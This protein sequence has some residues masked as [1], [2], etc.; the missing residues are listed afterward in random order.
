MQ[1]K[2][3]DR[4]KFNERGYERGRGFRGRPGYVTFHRGYVPG[5][6]IYAEK[7]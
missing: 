3:N 4:Q 5:T 2:E 6:G 7:V 1:K